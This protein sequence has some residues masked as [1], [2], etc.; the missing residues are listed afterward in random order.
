MTAYYA[1]GYLLLSLWILGV[2]LVMYW[3]TARGDDR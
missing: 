3:M 1:L 2:V